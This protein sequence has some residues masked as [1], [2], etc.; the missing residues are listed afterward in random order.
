MKYFAF[1]LVVAFF[2]GAA[3]VMVAML[4]DNHESRF[5]TYGIR[6]MGISWIVGVFSALFYFAWMVL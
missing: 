5:F 4:L 2:S 6:T 3:S 1:A